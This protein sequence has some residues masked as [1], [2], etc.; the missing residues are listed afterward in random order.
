[1][2]RAVSA[3][4]LRGSAEV[5][6]AVGQPRDGDWRACFAIWDQEQNALELVRCSY[7]VERT[8]KKIRDAGLPDFLAARLAN[9]H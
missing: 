6:C 8:Q 9:G 4:L 5:L 7:D 2:R 1:M 3:F